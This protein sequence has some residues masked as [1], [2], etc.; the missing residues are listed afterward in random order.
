MAEKTKLIKKLVARPGESTK[1]L[2]YAP[3]RPP[4]S[5]TKTQAPASPQPPPKKK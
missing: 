3:P 2:T 5:G 4:T 1:T